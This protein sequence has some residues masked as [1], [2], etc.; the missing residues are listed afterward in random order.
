MH[1]FGKRQRKVTLRKDN[2]DLECV[3]E[4]QEVDRYKYFYG[5]EP[6]KPFDIENKFQSG[7]LNQKDEQF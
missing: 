1:V 3:R 5:N 4:V 2:S 7:Y 6:L